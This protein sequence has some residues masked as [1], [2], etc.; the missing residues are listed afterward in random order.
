[1]DVTRDF[2]D[3]RDVVKAYRSILEKKPDQSLFALGS[4]RTVTIRHILN[5]LIKISG[6][7]IEPE[8]DSSLVRAKE[9]ANIA[10]DYSL[11]KE[12]LGWSPTIPIEQ[13]LEDIYNDIK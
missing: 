3:V 13:S 6:K 11:A 8:I 12:I 5:H 10:I 2:T 4:G 9:E 7:N 1:M